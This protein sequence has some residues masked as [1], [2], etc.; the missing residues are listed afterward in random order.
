[1][2]PRVESIYPSPVRIEATVSRLVLRRRV[3]WTPHFPGD[4]GDPIETHV[5]GAGQVKGKLAVPG[6]HG[7][8]SRSVR[9]GFSGHGEPE[10]LSQRV[11]HIR[12]DIYKPSAAAG[13]VDPTVLDTEWETAKARF[14]KEPPQLFLSY[15]KEK[16]RAHFGLDV[17]LPGA[18]LAGLAADVA[19]GLCE[20]VTL[21][22]SLLPS[23]T[24]LRYS[25]DQPDT[26]IWVLPSG[27]EAASG[28]QFGLL[29]GLEWGGRPSAD[30]GE[31]GTAPG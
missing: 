13:G 1:M 4:T 26:T 30:P 8:F 27:G 24:D 21:G 17:W 25:E 22:F 23:F 20:E 19:A 6:T 15:L 5:V 12:W 29:D 28:G 18:V 31:P 7:D 14:G 16:G 3:G 9:V 11:R 2:A 10:R